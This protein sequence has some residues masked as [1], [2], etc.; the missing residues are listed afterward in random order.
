M[1]KIE[2]PQITG[3]VT[4]D[5]LNA[6]PVAGGLYLLYGKGNELLYVGKTA[7]LKRRLIQHFN[8][9]TGDNLTDVAHNIAYAGYFPSNDPVEREIYETYMINTIKPA[10]NVEKVFTY[11]TRRYEEHWYNPD[12]L[13]EQKKIK[14]MEFQLL[15]AKIRALG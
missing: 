10:W 11:K 3:F 7:N 1:I 4:G 9:Y 13:V 8:F 15:A 12:E 5:N 2:V 14:E 6:V